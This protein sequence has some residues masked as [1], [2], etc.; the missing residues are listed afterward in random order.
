MKSLKLTPKPLRALTAGVLKWLDDKVWGIIP[1]KRVRW[2]GYDTGVKPGEAAYT[3]NGCTS[4]HGDAGQKV[5]IPLEE[6]GFY[7]PMKENTNRF[8]KGRS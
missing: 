6:I 8:V 4:P 3:I 1:R 5:D 2:L 7:Y